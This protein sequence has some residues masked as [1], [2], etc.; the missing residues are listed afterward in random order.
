MSHMRDEYCAPEQVAAGTAVL[1]ETV[2]RLDAV[3]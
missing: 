1:M 2:F 3:D